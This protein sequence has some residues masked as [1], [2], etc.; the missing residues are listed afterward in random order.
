MLSCRFYVLFQ[1]LYPTVV[2]V[3]VEFQK[4]IWERQEQDDGYLPKRGCREDLSALHFAPR[5][6]IWDREAGSVTGS[7]NTAVGNTVGYV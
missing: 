2:I 1:G 5:L 7:S 4:Q 3:L 6:S